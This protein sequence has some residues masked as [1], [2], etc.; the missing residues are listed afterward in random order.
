MKG[1]NKY[2]RAISKFQNQ[3]TIPVHQ[4]LNSLQIINC[5]NKVFEQYINSFEISYNQNNNEIKIIQ[6]NKII[7]K[8]KFYIIILQK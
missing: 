1:K 4:D 2:N 8:I 5:I 7:G 6:N 3:V